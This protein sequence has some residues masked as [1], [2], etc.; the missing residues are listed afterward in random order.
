MENIR[1][2]DLK[3]KTTED[4]LEELSKFKYNNRNIDLKTIEE[5]LGFIAEELTLLNTNNRRK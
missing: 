3:H 1:L 5:L 4:R 2:K